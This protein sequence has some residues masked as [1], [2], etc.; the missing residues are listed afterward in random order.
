M[1][2]D[3]P[4]VSEVSRK[5]ETLLPDLISDLKHLTAIPS[6][7]FPGYPTE[8]VVEA[9]DFV[10]GLLRDI[11]VDNIET[12]DLPDTSPIVFAEVEGRPNRRR[13]SS[14]PTTTF[15]RRATSPSGLTSRLSRLK[16]MASSM[17]GV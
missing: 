13:S 15:S 1:A 12:I 14:T 6:I 9:H 5:L 4:D 7:A 16:R 17:D 8:K 3:R 10:V 2:V 11:G